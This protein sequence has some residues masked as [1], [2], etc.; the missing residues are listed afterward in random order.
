MNVNRIYV[1]KIYVT[2]A[3]KVEGDQCHMEGTFLKNALVYHD[4]Y[5][6]YIDLVSEEN[7]D[8][9]IMHT[10]PGE[11]YIYVKGGLRPI[12]DVLDVSFKKEDMPKKKILRNINKAIL[13]KKKKED[14][15]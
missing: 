1:A 8:Y 5:G 4:G 11:M 14:D 12:C 10:F 6:N 15:K 2:T 9:G 13:L 3:M 7:Y